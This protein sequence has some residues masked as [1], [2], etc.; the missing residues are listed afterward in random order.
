MAYQLEV[1]RCP[2]C[3]RDHLLCW[4]HDGEPD[5]DA[6]YE[7]TCDETGEI[8]R[9]LRLGVIRDERAQCERGS[10]NVRLQI[11]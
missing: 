6:L 11:P 4:P 3:G 9:D 1:Y 10:V 7:Y 2:E 8:V 5:T